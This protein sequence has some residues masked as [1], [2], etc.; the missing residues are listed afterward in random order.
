M[1]PSKSETKAESFMPLLTVCIV[2][3]GHYYAPSVFSPCGSSTVGPAKVRK[4]PFSPVPTFADA[5][6][7]FMD[8]SFKRPFLCGAISQDWESINGPARCQRLSRVAGRES[9]RPRSYRGIP[10][11]VYLKGRRCCE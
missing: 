6:A 7:A 8:R 1:V 3:V 11:H 10:N 9:L 4:G 5:V 2:I